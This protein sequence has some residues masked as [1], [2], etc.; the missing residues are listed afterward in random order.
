M[1]ARLVRTSRGWTGAQICR[2]GRE[3]FDIKTLDRQAEQHFA[4]ASDH[5]RTPGTKLSQP[6]PD[7]NALA[8][9]K[10]NGSAVPPA[11]SH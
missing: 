5:D 6:T 9:P 2:E 10:Q 1:R 3:A 4:A 8:R 11:I 7:A